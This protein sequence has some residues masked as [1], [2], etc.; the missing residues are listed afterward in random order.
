MSDEIC[1]KFTSYD[2]I[3]LKEIEKLPYLRAVIDEAMRMLP[4]SPLGG[5]RVSPG[6]VIDKDYIPKGVSWLLFYA[7]PFL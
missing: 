2:N 5:M 3:T 6:V 7:Y 1:S 4:P